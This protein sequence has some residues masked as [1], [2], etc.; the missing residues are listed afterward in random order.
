MNNDKSLSV[1]S[2]NLFISYKKKQLRLC[3]ACDVFDHDITAVFQK[4]L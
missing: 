1:L 4:G 3:T 2:K